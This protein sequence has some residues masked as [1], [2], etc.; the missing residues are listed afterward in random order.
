MLGHLLTASIHGRA[1]Q[2]LGS[3]ATSLAAPAAKE[4]WS[5]WHSLCG[6][7][8]DGGGESN[9]PEDYRSQVGSSLSDKGYWRLD[10][11]GLCFQVLAERF[12]SLLQGWV[13]KHQHHHHHH[14][15]FSSQTTLVTKA[16]QNSFHPF[17]LKPSVV[18][19]YPKPWALKDIAGINQPIMKQI[20]AC[21]E[22]LGFLG[23]KGGTWDSV[24][25]FNSKCN[26]C[27]SSML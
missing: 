8:G 7:R 2:R 4:L 16:R 5:K 10:V 18:P 1:G 19:T 13:L 3:A 6:G 17:W 27:S 21:L 24:F 14:C 9:V 23:L 15:L 20:Q 25:V 12:S 22:G 11:I 26:W